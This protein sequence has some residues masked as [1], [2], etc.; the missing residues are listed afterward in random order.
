MCLADGLGY[1]IIKKK[2]QILMFFLT[3]ECILLLRMDGIYTEKVDC[4]GKYKYNKKGDP[5]CVF[6]VAG[7]T[8]PQPDYRKGY[9]GYLRH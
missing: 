4:N 2:E 3:I 5:V 8:L 7:P 6:G 9:H 1:N